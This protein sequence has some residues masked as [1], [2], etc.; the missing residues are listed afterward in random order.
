MPEIENRVRSKKRERVYEVAF[1]LFSS[2]TDWVSFFREIL[3]ADGL[4]RRTYPTQEALAEFE[5]SE[6]Y[7]EILR[8]LTRL[9]EKA[10]SPDGPQ[11]PTRV[12]TVRLPMSVHEALRV[13]ADERHT[14]V[15]K[16]CISKLVQFIENELIP[17]ERWRR[18]LAARR[19]GH[20]TH[21]SDEGAG[22]DL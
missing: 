20:P 21:T 22:A 2:G 19:E 7:A 14:S 13:E 16:L 11:E 12:I 8:M 6:T 5:R 18:S 10:V 17:R 1:G 15:N 9:R 4:V 3:G